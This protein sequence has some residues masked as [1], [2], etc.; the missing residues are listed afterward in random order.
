MRLV[1]AI[2]VLL[3]VHPAFSQTAPKKSPKVQGLLDVLE[4]DTSSNQTRL[5]TLHQ[6]IKLERPKVHDTVIANYY[7]GLAR[8]AAKEE[9]YDDGIAYCDTALNA[10]PKMGFKYRQKVKDRKASVLKAAGKTEEAIKLYLNVLSAYEKAKDTMGWMKMNNQ[11]GVVHKQVGDLE[12]AIYYFKESIRLSQAIG[13]EK[14]EASSL[15]TL[16]NC[17]KK[18]ERFEE[19]E[20][21]YL[22]SIAICKRIGLKRELAGNYNNIGSLKRMTGKPNEAMRYYFRAVDLN[23]EL[24]NDK[25]LSY[26]YNNIGTIYRNKGQLQQALNYFTKSLEIKKKLGD[27]RGEIYTHL[28][29]AELYA[30]MNQYERAFFHHKKFVRMN[31]SIREIDDRNA[32]QKLAKEF[33]TEKQEAEIAKLNAQHALS[34]EKIRA[35]DERIVYQNFLAWL[36]GIGSFLLLVVAILIWR[37]SMQRKRSNDEL[38]LRN[39]QIRVKNRQLDEKNQEITDSISYA[40][41]IQSTILPAEDSLTTAFKSYSILYL[42]KDIVSGDFYVVHQSNFGTYFGVVDC[43]GHGVP[44]AMVSLVGASLLDKAINEKHLNSTAAI[45]DDL[46]V[47]M[48]KAFE[49]KELIRDGMDMALC[50]LNPQKTQLTF[51]GA[52]R[53]CWVVN[54][55]DQFQERQSEFDVF[56]SNEIGDTKL[57]EIK[58]DRQGIGQTY[59]TRPFTEKS[60]SVASGDRVVLFTDGYPDQFGGSENKKFKNNRLKEAIL[61]TFKDHPNDVTRQLHKTLMEWR[62][63]EM[64]VDD[65]CLLV[66]DIA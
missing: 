36:M 4:S 44:G 9:Q 6:L 65:I 7:I 33:Q 46:K 66:A 34:E 56:K 62:G 55:V 16:G 30:D 10:C 3:L 8:Y 58:G 53:N 64:Q 35:R 29:V 59:E 22:S 15:M 39:K 26:N 27:D 1:T 19:A 18:L 40:K 12:N 32:A 24:G 54:K 49:S 17:Y 11:M 43:T 13:S 25:W 47:E 61:R 21:V 37:S 14:W 51:S 41:R 28:N 52:H 38:A 5:N 2:V 57:Y 31:D 42:P 63:D 60:V 20:E 50:R 23:K 48:P 45:L